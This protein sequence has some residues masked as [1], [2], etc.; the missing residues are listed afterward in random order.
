[1]ELLDIYDSNRRR[2][3]L[4]RDRSAP[5][6]RGQYDLVV[7]LM[8]VDRDNRVFCTRRS[9]EKSAFPGWWESTG[10]AARAGENSLQAAV[11]E[12][13]EETGLYADPERL[14]LLYSCQGEGF[15]RDVFLT[16]MDFPLEQVVF[17]PGETDGAEWLPYEEW[18]KRAMD[19]E[20]PYLSPVPP[21][22]HEFYGVLR[23][24][25]G[26]TALDEA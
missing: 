18:E 17:Q 7:V 20:A 4:T 5:L 9:P 25:L 24:H 22:P 8:V 15:F 19:G 6:E 10:G 3:G 23:K 1:M 13:R 21:G 12:L 11:R 2:T 16:R 26:I 14:T